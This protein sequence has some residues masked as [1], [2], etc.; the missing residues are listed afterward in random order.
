MKLLS[1]QAVHVF[2]RSKCAYLQRALCILNGCIMLGFSGPEA[3][4]A[5]LNWESFPTLVLC[6]GSQLSVVCC[7]VVAACVNRSISDILHYVHMIKSEFPP[8]VVY[9]KAPTSDPAE[10]SEKSDS[11]DVLISIHNCCILVP[12]TGWSDRV[13][14]LTTPRFLFTPSAGSQFFCDAKQLSL[15]ECDPSYRLFVFSRYQLGI[16][17]RLSHFGKE[18]QFLVTASVV[19]QANT[20][21]EDAAAPCL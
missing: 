7:E 18:N 14:A 15:C 2:Q 10:G 8:P 4:C 6:T 16:P 3:R 5:L 19:L 17:A 21:H 12:E 1:L 9:H 20:K 13:F 11:L